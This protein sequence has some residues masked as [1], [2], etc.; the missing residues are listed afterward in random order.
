[1]K[2]TIKTAIFALA[3]AVTVSASA[4]SYQF[5]TNLKV[6]SRGA[7]VTALQDFLTATGHYTYGVSTGYFGNVTKAAVAAYQSAKGISPAVGF[8][9]PLTRASV[10]GSSIV[11]PGTPTTPTTP[12]LNGQE[13]FGDFRLSPSPVNDTNIQRNSDVA[14]YGVEVKAKNADI[15]VERITLDVKVATDAL[16]ASTEN[17][18]TLINKITIKDGSTVLATIPVNS[19][20]FSKISGTSD[21]YVQISGLS[22]RVAKDTIKTF[23]ASFDTNS[24]DSPRYVKVSVSDTGV[25]VVDGRGISTYNKGLIGTREHVFKK[26]GASTLAVKTDAVTLYASN[27]RVNTTSNGAEKALTSTFAVK[28]ET[29][30][31]KLTTVTVKAISTGSNPTNIY[32]YQGS[33]LLDARTASTTGA[34]TTEAVFDIENSNVVVAQDTTSTFTVKV[35]MPATTV[36]GSVVTTEVTAVTFDKA[37]GSSS[38]ATIGTNKGPYNFFASI[39]PMFAKT[40][41]TIA[42]SSGTDAKGVSATADIRLNLTAVGGDIKVSSTTAVIG[43]KNA[44]TNALVATS[45]VAVKPADSNLAYFTDGAVKAV[46]L[47]DVYA[48]STVTS[49]T[50]L[51]AFVQSVTYYIGNTPYTLSEGLE[52]F[53]SD[54]SQT[55]NK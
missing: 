32:L 47:S 8:F 6:G 25:R 42:V 17:P 39:V 44:S 35:D 16:Y 4:A 12:V 24:I 33:T 13:G 20:T 45:S 1:M 15:S 11:N 5:N 23:T 37:D 21:Y 9:G 18:S 29:G 22:T 36:N 51:K 7:D 41:S 54:N 40:S 31:S 3:L 48:S 50:N 34:S 26:P 38:S 53:D 49:T 27:Y 30:P 55:F 19:S 28:S 46:T 52:A 14:V 43:L 2:T 10:N